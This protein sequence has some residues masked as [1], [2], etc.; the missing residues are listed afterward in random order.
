MAKTSAVERN[1]KREKMVKRFAAKRAKLKAIA[2]DRALAPEERFAARLKL[3]EMPRNS[4]AVRIHNRCELTGRP[5]ASFHGWRTR[6]TGRMSG[7]QNSTRTRE[8]RT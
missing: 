3:S 6:M 4:S 1:R 5:R 8:E 7:W 2:S